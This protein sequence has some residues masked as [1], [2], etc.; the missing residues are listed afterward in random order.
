[1]V[2]TEKEELLLFPNDMLNDDDVRCFNRAFFL[3]QDR[4]VSCSNA[5]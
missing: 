4:G 2:A 5:A 1:M 3:Y